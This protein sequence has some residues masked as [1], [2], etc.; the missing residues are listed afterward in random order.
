MQGNVTVEGRIVTKPG[1][2]IKEDAALEFNYE[3]PKY[4]SRAGLKL[5]KALEHFNI[6]PE[7][8]I[9]LDAGISTGGFTDC[10]LK[11]GVTKVYGVDVGYG[12]VHEKIRVD[13]RVIIMERTNLRELAPLPEKVDIVTLDLSFIS[14]LKVMDAVMNSMKEDAHLI[15]LIK[16]Q[17]EAQRE[18]VGR[19]GIIK[20]KK[21]H[22]EVIDKV[23]L[24]IKEFG[25]KLIGVI[26]SPITGSSGNK[27]FLGY[28]KRIL[29]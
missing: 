8:L 1:V 12:Q 25:F 21:V 14:V 18:Q 5:E 19:G 22:K 6:K 16:P 3:E 9:A 20:D 15:I 4:V 10:L 13:P 7:G 11:N 29:P 23:T 26:D 17:F 28:F 2:Q 27:E 24:G